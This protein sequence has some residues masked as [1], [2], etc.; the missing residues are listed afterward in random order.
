[1]ITLY[2]T[3][4]KNPLIGSARSGK[5]S[6]AG[7]RNSRT[8]LLVNHYGRAK[9]AVANFQAHHLSNSSNQTRPSLWPHRE[10]VKKLKELFQFLC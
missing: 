1:L 6:R 5:E 8:L 9:L 3:S 10:L 2:N 4:I 7:A